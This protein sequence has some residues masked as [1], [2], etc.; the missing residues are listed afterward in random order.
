MLRIDVPAADRHGQNESMEELFSFPEQSYGIVY[1]TL[2][3]LETSD[4]R[5]DNAASQNPLKVGLWKPA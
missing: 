4:L 2:C 5:E 3:A 1:T